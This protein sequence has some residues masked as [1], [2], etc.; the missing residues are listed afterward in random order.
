MKHLLALFG[1]ISLTDESKMDYRNISVCIALSVLVRKDD[2]VT[3]TSNTQ[4]VIRAFELML[5]HRNALFPDIIDLF[6]QRLVD[7]VVP[8]IYHD[9]FFNKKQSTFFKKKEIRRIET[10][11]ALFK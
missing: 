1:R 7:I 6:K 3:I 9:I 11:R 5:K 10:R 8:P 4:V 2:V